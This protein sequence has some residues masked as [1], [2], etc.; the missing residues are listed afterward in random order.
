M[1]IITNDRFKSVR[2]HTKASSSKARSSIASFFSPNSDNMTKLYNPAT[3][4]GHPLIYR[5]THI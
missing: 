5:A 4:I 2:H 1:Q 3:A